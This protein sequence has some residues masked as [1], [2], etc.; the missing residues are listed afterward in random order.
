VKTRSK[1]RLVQ[2]FALFH[3]ITLKR[4]HVFTVKIQALQMCS[5]LVDT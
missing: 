1:R 3:L 5:L 2:I 4:K